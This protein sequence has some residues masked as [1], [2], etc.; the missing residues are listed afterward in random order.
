MVSKKELASVF[1]EVADTLVDDFDLIDFLHKLT[2]DAAEVS[3]TASAGI[4]LADMGGSL[5]FMAAS[6]P[7]AG[8]LERLQ[9]EYG[10]GPCIEC[11]QTLAAV[12]ATDLRTAH[13]RWP[14]FAPAALDAGYLSV[15]AFPMR[16]RDRA[17][18]GL[19]IF[20]RDA[21]D[22]GEGGDGAAVI[23][24][25]ADVATIAL[26]QER[27]VT[28][29]ENLAEQLQVA[30]NSRIVIEQ[31]KGVISSEYDVTVDEAFRRMRDYARRNQI[32]LTE[33][34]AQVVSGAGGLPA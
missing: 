15:H 20:G 11:Y 21:G 19:N 1:V 23:Q 12:K 8:R 4:M 28:T 16:S 31:A 33:F 24:A 5:Q 6:E 22:P 34:A 17:I 26:L 14:R 18:G 10:E 25:L 9:V 30:L 27:A 29:A 7:D 2:D 32:R 3:G 13:D